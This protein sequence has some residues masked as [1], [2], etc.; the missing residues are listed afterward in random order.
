[1]LQKVLDELRKKYRVVEFE[2][3]WL[4]HGTVTISKDGTKVADLWKESKHS[5]V[6]DHELQSFVEKRV[7]AF[8]EW[9]GEAIA[10]LP[11]YEEWRLE[12]DQLMPW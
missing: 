9:R 6:F 8:I 1:M 7:E 12:H 3:Y 5:S 4:I 10:A 2:K 11:T